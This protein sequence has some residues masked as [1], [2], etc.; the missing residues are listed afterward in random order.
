MT[1]VPLVRVRGP[2]Q[3]D[4]N[5][6][7]RYKQLRI[8]AALLLALVTP[9]IALADVMVLL[10]G[11]LGSHLD[12][13]ISGFN[14]V[15][16][17]AGW[18]DGGW[19]D[20]VEHHAHLNPVRQASDDTFYALDLPSEAALAMQAARLDDALHQILSRHAGAK[21]IFTGFSA[22]GVVARLYMVQHPQL[23]VR[24][25]CTIASPHL[26]T[27]SAALALLAA[28]SGLSAYASALGADFINHSQALYRDLLPEQADNFLYKLN[29]KPHPPARYIAIVRVNTD[30]EPGDWVVPAYSQDMNNVAALRGKVQTITTPGVHGV[31][32]ADARHLLDALAVPTPAPAPDDL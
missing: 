15:L 6:I 9:G 25:L 32:A 20:T 19:I 12:W 21:I 13:R 14:D 7:H 28:D 1:R 17:A 2:T 4:M 27:D 23:P 29:R 3:L 26:G 16:Q 31:L 22:G 8:I 24:A 11:H 5:V 18:H 10:H 30:A